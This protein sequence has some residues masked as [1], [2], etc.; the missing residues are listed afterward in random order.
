MNPLR[1][2]DQEIA[3]KSVVRT[4]DHYIFQCGLN[5]LSLS[6]HNQSLGGG[7]L[8]FGVGHIGATAL[9]PIQP[10]RHIEIV[11]AGLRITN[12][13]SS[14]CMAVRIQ[15][16]DISKRREFSKKTLRSSLVRSQFNER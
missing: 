12:L 4:Y 14:S 11:S 5:L 3:A 7:Q 10:N 15:D 6:G 8:L 2:R 9:L 1:L 13:D 16:L